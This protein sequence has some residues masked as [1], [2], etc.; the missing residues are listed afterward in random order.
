MKHAKYTTPLDEISFADATFRVT[1]PDNVVRMQVTDYIREHGGT[2]VPEKADYCIALSGEIEELVEGILLTPIQFWLAARELDRIQQHEWVEASLAFLGSGTTF[3]VVNAEKI[4]WYIRDNREK[5]AEEMIR[6][7]IPEV[8]EGYLEH[9]AEILPSSMTALAKTMELDDQIL[10]DLVDSLL[11]KATVQEK[12][13]MKAWLLEYKQ[14][15]LSHAF[16]EETQQAE[17]EKELGF[18]ER[19]EY[20][21]MKLFS[22]ITEE[23]GIRISGYLGTDDLVFIPDN[24]AGKDVISVHVRNFYA[25]HRD[26]QFFWQRP[27]YLENTVDLEALTQAK[28][29]DLV[30]FGQYPQTKASQLQPIQWRVLKKEGSRLLVVSDLCLDKAPYHQNLENVDWEHCHLRKWFNGPFYQ[31]A[32]TMEEQA[33]IPEV[34]VVTAPNE[35]YHTSGG[36]DTLD[37]IFALSTEE[38]QLLGGDADRLGYTTAYHQVQ[39]Y[40]FGGKINCWWLRTPGVEPDFVTL[41]G[42]SGSIGTYGYRVDHNEYAVRPAMWIELGGVG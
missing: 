41:V 18:R 24:I 1:G 28:V 23:D 6:Q 10:L 3:P 26:L 5:V 42:N 29:G 30:A 27:A 14:N 31:L 16:L 37:H 13:E 21:W 19:N 39:G 2:L 8:V 17:L 12:H 35:K 7:N 22:Y 36:G 11:E 32:F 34:T 9:R 20:D 25:D 33:M 40:Y 15:H 38:A 4:F